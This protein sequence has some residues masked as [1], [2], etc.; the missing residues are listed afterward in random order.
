MQFE[1]QDRR[2][3]A[4]AEKWL[5]GTITPAEEKEFADWYNNNTDE[6]LQVPADFAMSEEAHRQRI[7][8]N[9]QRL[10]SKAVK[11]ISI[12]R[13]WFTRIAAAAAILILIST[14]AYQWFR[15]P[16]NEGITII[17]SK[18][19]Q[20][21]LAPGGKKAILTLANGSKIIL[22]SAANGTLTQQG[23]TKILKLN[24]GQLAYREFGSSGAQM[25][26]RRR[27]EL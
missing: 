11:P 26:R 20:K 24:S 4:L 19:L 2:Y 7:L 5:N 12:Q 27:C 21:D 15:K 8:Q 18:Q 23:N 17:H 10:R 25:W 3:E 22:D 13:R 9:I 6:P 16:G 14:G 1:S